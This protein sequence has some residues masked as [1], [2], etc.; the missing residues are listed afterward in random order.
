MN[1][2][3]SLD[4]SVLEFIG[5]GL[6]SI[7]VLQM[8]RMAAILDSS[9]P[10][11]R[12]FYFSSKLDLLLL[13]SFSSFA[14]WCWYISLNFGFLRKICVRNNLFE[15]CRSETISLLSMIDALP[16]LK[17]QFPRFFVFFF[18]NLKKLFQCLYVSGFAVDK[19]NIILIRKCY[20][21]IILISGRL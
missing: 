17:F 21:F 8:W 13:E 9:L 12:E 1:C 10:A 19:Y 4:V 14:V 11:L 3:F 20:F 7:W 18:Q 2:I 6:S 5:L 15:N 16:K